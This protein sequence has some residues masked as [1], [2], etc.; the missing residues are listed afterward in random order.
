MEHPEKERVATEEVPPQAPSQT[1]TLTSKYG[2]PGSWKWH[3]KVAIPEGRNRGGPRRAAERK[4]GPKVDEGP[5]GGCPFW[6]GQPD[7]SCLRES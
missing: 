4:E 6:P 3:W 5:R 7:G 1:R 2:G